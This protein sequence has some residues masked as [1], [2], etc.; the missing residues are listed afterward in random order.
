M[1]G[2]YC[3]DETRAADV[4]GAVV[5]ELDPD[6]IHLGEGAHGD[7]GVGVDALRRGGEVVGFG[8]VG[9]G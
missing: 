6:E 9:F 8:G 7:G 4:A 3:G 2:G 5:V 1:P